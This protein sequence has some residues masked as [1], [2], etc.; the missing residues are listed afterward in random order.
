M[1]K[2]VKSLGYL[3]R[4]SRFSPLLSFMKNYEKIWLP[5][6]DNHPRQKYTDKTTR[7]TQIDQS[8][9]DSVYQSK[10]SEM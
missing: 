10:Y 9:Y 6:H 5:A 2:A 3:V 1:F 8:I 4:K 7:D